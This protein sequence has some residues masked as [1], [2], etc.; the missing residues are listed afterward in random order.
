[1]NKLIGLALFLVS[2]SLLSV[3]FLS[4]C[5][6]SFLTGAAPA[7]VT[8]TEETLGG[9]AGDQG[10]D[11]EEGE[12]VEINDREDG[13]AEEPGLATHT[14]KMVDGGFSVAELK[15]KAG[16]TVVWQNIRQGRFKTAMV[17][18]VRECRG[19]KS[20]SFD[21]GESY[22]WTFEEA[23]ECTVV[24]GIYTEETM[25]VVVE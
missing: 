12:E 18:G 4:G 9:E 3:L 25:K 23:G 14:V 10:I 5:Q 6:G 1:M 24:D 15:V 2:L 11:T 22:R 21:S 13:E 19:I 7:V 16:D 8:T 17:M 20:G